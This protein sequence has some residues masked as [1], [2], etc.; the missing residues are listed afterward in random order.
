MLFDPNPYPTIRI[1]G[2]EGERDTGQ[3]D[4][5]DDAD[6]NDDDVDADTDQDD[7]EDDD[8]Q[9]GSDSDKDKDKKPKGKSLEDQ[10]DDERRARQKLERQIARDK[11]AKEQ[12]EADKDAVKDR[13]KYK[14]KLEARD[15][16]LTENLLIMEINKQSKF[17]F[18]DVEDVIRAFKHDEVHIDLD[19]DEPSVEGL[20]LALKRIARDKPHFLKKTKE[21]Q[22]GDEQQPPSGSKAGN[23]KAESAE[24]EAERLG[25]KFK[26]PGYSMQAV[27][28]V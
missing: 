25:K 8:S 18:I 27:R 20:D 7:L 15:K 14:A 5:P 9:D 22:D 17:K 23:G 21:E 26:I 28:P 19:A 1:W 2:G 13:D 4:P 6:Q 10:L 3:Q 24:A 11:A 16:F 12:L